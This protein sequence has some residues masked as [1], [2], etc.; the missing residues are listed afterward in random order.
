[1]AL[2]VLIV[3]DSPIIRKMVRRAIEMC[4]LPI[5]ELHQAGD[6]VEAL[7]ILADHW[8]DIVFADINMPN[9]DGVEM[10]ERMA[11]DQ[12]LDKIPVVIVS[13]ERS[14]TR[15]AR[16]KELGVRAYLTKPFRPE[17]FRDV[18]REVLPGVC[19]V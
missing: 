2:N 6:G 17:T 10:V 13:T 15:I 8:I 11:K 4:G 19:D 9:M 14:E 18:V 12:L 1:M 7:K 16:L 3:D 5:G